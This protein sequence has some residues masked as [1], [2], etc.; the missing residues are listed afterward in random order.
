MSQRTKAY[1]LVSVACLTLGLAPFVPE[2]HILGKL[3]WILGGGQGMQP[4][5]WWDTIQHGAPWLVLV[6][7]ALRDAAMRLLRGRQK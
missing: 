1:A 2:P 6:L 7:M 3:R 4:M 5:D